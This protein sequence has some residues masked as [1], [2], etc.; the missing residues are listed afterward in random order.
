METTQAS[1]K[2][3]TRPVLLEVIFRER[4]FHLLDWRHHYQATWISGMP[5][6]GKTAPMA[7]YL[8]LRRLPCVCYTLDEGDEDL[9]SFFYSLGL[10][11]YGAAR[12]KGSS[13]PLLT[14][15][16]L[17][18]FLTF[19]RRYFEE[20][21]TRVTPPF[22]LVFDDY[23]KVSPSSSFHEAFHN[24]MAMIPHDIH[25]V[26][27]SRTDPPPPFARMLAN[28]RMRL[29]G[30]K[31]LRLS[32]V[33]SKKIAELASGKRLS[34]KLMEENFYQKLMLCYNQLG[35]YADAVKTYHRYKETFARVLGVPVS[36]Q[37]DKI[38]AFLP[39]KRSPAAPY[40]S[41]VD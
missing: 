2:K 15:E 10:A 40:G 20:L 13:F 14:P 26:V 3:I 38:Y 4:L 28:N 37:T 39:F 9:A 27:L 29:V 5:G 19:S 21:C 23:Q 25:A 22:F 17:H 12:C 36:P 8:A 16:Y 32:L 11:G 18:N 24:G 35:R 30:Q 31:D 34:A 6:S 1:I 7:S 41:H 33:E